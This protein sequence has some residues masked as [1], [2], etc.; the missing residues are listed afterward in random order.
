MEDSLTSG[1]ICVVCT[2][3][4]HGI[5]ERE[6]AAFDSLYPGAVIEL[7]EG[8]S[9]EAVRALFA[10]ECDL[11]AISRE[12]E[13]VE[14]AAAIRGGLELEG[15]R[16]ARDGVALVVHTANV[17]E[18]VAL[19]QVRAIYSGTI[20]G[21]EAFGGSRERIQP[22]IHRPDSDI[23]A[24]FG[25][26]VMN[27]EPIRAPVV[28]QTS[29]SGVAAYVARHPGAIG[30]VSMAWSER[31]VKPLR[32]A[33]LKGL[34]YWKPDAETV[35]RGDYP[36]A[37]DMNLYVRAKGPALANGLITFTTSREGQA[38]VRDAGLVPIAVPVRFVRRSPLMGS[39]K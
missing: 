19:D 8:S 34:P 29:D 26:K 35:Y 4:V 1:R 33:T 32:L 20:T 39:H 17:V 5:L 12:L 3:E 6:R 36:L 10:A 37:R 30:M 2:P 23:M 16:F 21:W 15:Y 13:P 31:G 9:S 22:V 27:G 7:R 38:I 28:Y 18:N 14:R 25:A 24:Y 11:A